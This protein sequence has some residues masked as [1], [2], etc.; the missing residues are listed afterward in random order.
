M[1]QIIDNKRR[2]YIVYSYRSVI[3]EPSKEQAIILK[4]WINA[5][6]WLYN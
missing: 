5:G 6:R 3:L 1:I 4:Q 2:I